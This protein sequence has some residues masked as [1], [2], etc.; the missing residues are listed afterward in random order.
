MTSFVESNPEL[1]SYWRVIIL[2]GRNSASYKF[3]LA[4]TLLGL[5]KN[6]ST[7][8]LDELAEPY[9]KKICRHLELADRQG[10]STSSKFLSVCRDFN[11]GNASQDELIKGTVSLGFANV[12]DA[13]HIVNQEET[14][15][16]FFIDDRK[17]SNGIILTDEL[18]KIREQA[19]FGNLLP[20]VE[21]RWRLVETAWDLGIS[22]NLLQ[23]TFDETSLGLYVPV[24]TSRRV[25]ITSSRDALNGYQKGKC[26]Y[27]GKDISIEISSQNLA[28]I[29]HFF[30]HILKEFDEFSVV[31][32]DG[33][34]NLV[35]S[36]VSCNRG[37][38]GKFAR[39]PEVVY[40]E[41]L[42]RR[43]EYL[44]SSHHPLRETLI[45]QTGKSAALRRQFLQLMDRMAI[46]HLIHRWSAFERAPSTL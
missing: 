39:V 10:T 14:Q 22:P 37:P 24:D 6:R 23:V 34:W 16:R 7:F 41:R 11:N 12:I 15:E 35:L 20:E 25:D 21:A 42:Y 13:F 32:I 30:P 9:A 5:D 29:D 1:E 3:A 19:Q 4:Q 44:I 2:L 38:D 26:F 8:S 27:C 33:V 31:N 43:N 18:F 45:N 46:N 28:D 40:L 36:C 17:N